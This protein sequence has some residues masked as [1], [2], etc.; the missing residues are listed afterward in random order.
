MA[1]KPGTITLNTSHSRAHG[2]VAAFPFS[3]TGSVSNV[4]NIVPASSGNGNVVDGTAS[5]TTASYETGR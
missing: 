4:T 5:G 1:T 3:G 2:L